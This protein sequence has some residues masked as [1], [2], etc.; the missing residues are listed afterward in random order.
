MNSKRLDS[1]K[2]TK[3]TTNSLDNTF[4]TTVHYSESE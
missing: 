3:K 1:R 4:T 2:N